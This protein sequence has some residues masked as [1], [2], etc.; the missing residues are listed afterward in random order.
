MNYNYYMDKNKTRLMDQDET[1]VSE[2]DLT[3]SN[4]PTVMSE[5]FDPGM[6]LRDRGDTTGE[7]TMSVFGKEDI[8][9][10]L[11]DE[12]VEVPEIGAEDMNTEYL[13]RLVSKPFAHRTEEERLKINRNFLRDAEPL[14]LERLK[15]DIQNAPEELGTGFASL[16]RW[17]SIPNRKFTLI[18]SRPQHGKTTFMLNMLLNMC[19]K[20]PEQHFLYYSYGE[21]RQDVEI[22]LINMCGGK[23]FSPLEIHGVTNNFKRW[24]HELKS[25]DIDILKEKAEKNPEYR[26]LKNFIEISS[27]IHVMDGNYNIVDLLDSLKAFNSTLPIGAAFIDFLQA[28]RPDK[29][30]LPLTRQ[31]QL[32]E[33]VNQLMERSN[34]T[35]FPFIFGAQLTRGEQNIPEYDGLTMKC[36]KDFKDPEQVASL[37][38]ALQNY[39]KSDF[40]GSNVNQHFKSRFFQY[41]LKK[42]EKV[43][44]T[45][46]D[47]HPNTAILAKVLVNRGGPAPEVELLFNK[48]LMKITDFANGTGHV[49]Q[50]DFLR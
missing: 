22:K 1:K 12:L 44:E 10:K 35:K 38:I 19:Q 31:Q 14:T 16:D 11:Q 25:H 21:P 50:Y 6:T 45:F 39:A 26:G 2:S 41:T 5:P 30:S 9:K 8:R 33:T 13:S 47:K 3:E 46:K 36:L 4:Q 34:D 18:A 37:I 49:N 28:V 43:P 15:E 40:I 20:Y 7:Q 42:A 27:R 23:P 29:G 48:W 17:L 32:Q 24:K